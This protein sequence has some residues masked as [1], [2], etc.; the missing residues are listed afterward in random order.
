MSRN[1]DTDG[2]CDGDELTG[3]TLGNEVVG[4]MVVGV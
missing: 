2:V 4:S 3:L 1:V